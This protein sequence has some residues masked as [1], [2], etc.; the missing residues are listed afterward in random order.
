LVKL[1]ILVISKDFVDF[2]NSGLPIDWCERRGKASHI[3]RR[4]VCVVSWA[5]R[6]ADQALF[7]SG[8]IRTDAEGNFVLDPAKW[9]GHDHEDRF[10]DG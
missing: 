8:C 10:H 7:P 9:D 6:E 5:S 4:E 1:V 3:G 2:N